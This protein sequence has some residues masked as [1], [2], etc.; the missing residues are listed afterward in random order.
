MRK[1]FLTIFSI[2]A[3]GSLVFTSSCKKYLDVDQYTTD[4]LTFDSVFVNRN[5]TEQW[6]WHTYSFLNN[7]GAEITNKGYSA[8]SWASDEAVFGDWDGLCEKYQNCL[9]TPDNE[10]SEDRWGLEYEGI[11]HASIFIHNVDKCK[12]LSN[13][14]RAEYKAQARFL[15]AYYYW[16]LIKQYGPVP[17][18]PDEGQDISKS[19]SELVLPRNTYDECVD[20]ITKEF[21]QAATVLPLSR[22]S[23]SIGQPTRG[24]ALAARAKVFLF[25]ASPLYNGNKDLFNLV[26]NKGKQLINQTYSEEKWAKAAAAAKEVIDLGVYELLRVPRTLTSMPAPDPMMQSSYPNGCSDF[27]PYLSY[28]SCF[29]GDVTGGSNPEFVYARVN[30]NTE[31]LTYISR[32]CIPNG[33]LGGW[34]TI[35]ASLK[36]VDAYQMA[37]GKDIHNSSAE[38]P[39]MET[40]FTNGA[41]VPYLPADVSYQYVNREPRFYASIAFNGSVWENASSSIMSHHNYQSFY[42]KDDSK[43]NGIQLSSPNWYLRTGI[44][45]KKYYSPDDSWDDGGGG[46]RKPRLEPAIR[47]ADVLLWYA[48]ALNELTKSYTVPSFSE[49]AG[50]EITVARTVDQ[51]KYGMK[52]VRCRAGLPDLDEAVYSNPDAFRTALKHERQVELFMEAA[53]YFDLRRWKDAEVQEAMPIMGYNINMSAADNQKQLFYTDRKPIN[54]NKVFL[55]KMYLWP[56]PTNE[57]RRNTAVT[58]NPGWSN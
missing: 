56:L 17:L 11:R 19:Y 30:A 49:A 29:N 47:Y 40:G 5:Y 48:E 54:I 52:R 22:P 34:N 14:E 33:A 46:Y 39:Y 9:Y 31:D 36:Q 15:R 1:S 4:M 57:I 18:L 35:A 45:V 8:F 38:I 42:Y 16:M 44:G 12:E 26:D 7:R 55:K 25:A 13:G 41:D 50:T 24:S 27:D 2:L 43:G 20:F 37:D 53:R 23:S 28:K 6:L 51:M 3:I 10:L 21:A 58:Q 32:H